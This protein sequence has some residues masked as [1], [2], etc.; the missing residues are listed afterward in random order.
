MTDSTNLTQSN[1][2]LRKIGL[3]WQRSNYGPFLVVSAFFH[4]CI[5]KCLTVHCNSSV[6]PMTEGK[7]N[8]LYDQH[9]KTSYPNSHN[10][11]Y[12]FWFV[13]HFYYTHTHPYLFSISIVINLYSP[14][15][16]EDQEINILMMTWCIKL[17]E[18]TPFLI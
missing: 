2:V 16:W 6:P 10:K 4:T 11:L 9:I 5:C 18:E 13:L 17:N 3:K 7:K 8:T 1:N 12:L 14:C 15:V